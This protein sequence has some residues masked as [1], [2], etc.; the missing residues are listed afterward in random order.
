[1]TSISLFPLMKKS[2][3]LRPRRWRHQQSKYFYDCDKT[4]SELFQ[5]ARDGANQFG[6]R[7]RI[8]GSSRLLSPLDKNDHLRRG[9][10]ETLANRLTTDFPVNCSPPSG[11][12]VVCRL[13][14]LIGLGLRLPWKRDW[15]TTCYATGPATIF[16]GIYCRFWVFFDES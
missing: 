16:E 10:Y 7:K 6:V 2:I 5:L 11:T 13:F 9:D 4:I 12:W 15:R 1:M 3:W 14:A 8:F